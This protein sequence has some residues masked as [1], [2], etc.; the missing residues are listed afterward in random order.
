MVELYT[1]NIDQRLREVISE[2]GIP[3]K[4]LPKIL[5]CSAAQSLSWWSNLSKLNISE[6][7]FLNLSS[8]LGIHETRLFEGTYDISLAQKRVF[9]DHTSLPDRYLCRQNSYIRTS[10]HIYKYLCLTRGKIFAHQVLSELNVSPNIYLSPDLPINITFFGD[11][12]AML[13][14]KGLSS[15][16]LDILASVIFLSLKNK[17]IGKKFELAESYGDVYR[18]F[19]ENYNYF[20]SNFEITGTA[21]GAS[22]RLTTVMDLTKY[23]HLN[24]NHRML[25]RLLRYRLMFLA[26]V[27]F[28]A[29]LTPVFPRSETVYKSQTVEVTYYL[30][31][32]ARQQLSLLRLL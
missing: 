9:G 29:N 8:H 12:L 24:E 7:S 16:E 22:Y 31:P 17:P 5:E 28:L 20:D 25:E 6:K 13:D 2:I 10:E 32:P 1:S 27:P 11:L 21:N 26:W 18:I 4:F 30:K 15:Q 14:S 19:I 23:P 3:L